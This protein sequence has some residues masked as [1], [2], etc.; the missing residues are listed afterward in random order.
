MKSLSSPAIIPGDYVP[1][2]SVGIPICVSADH[3]LASLSLVQM[4]EDVDNCSSG[5]KVIIACGRDGKVRIQN[6]TGERDE[7]L[8]WKSM[9]KKF[10]KVSVL[11]T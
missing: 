6:E 5:E 8:S 7:N 4:G 10:H 1:P 11:Y 2:S 3:R 9:A